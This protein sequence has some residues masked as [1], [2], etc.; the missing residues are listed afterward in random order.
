VLDSPSRCPRN[1]EGQSFSPLKVAQM[2]HTKS[3]NDRQGV[4]I[5]QGLHEAHCILD[6]IQAEHTGRMKRGASCSY[7]ADM[8]LGGEVQM[9]SLAGSGCVCTFA[10]FVVLSFEKLTFSGIP[11]FDVI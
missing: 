4:H 6:A 2:S 1:S 5:C 3:A 8:V 7:E 10:R 9:E 11:E